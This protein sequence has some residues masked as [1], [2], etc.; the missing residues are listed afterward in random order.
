MKPTFPKWKVN[1]NEGLC[2]IS[3]NIVS[4]AEAMDLLTQMM[5]MEPSRRISA[6]AA[7]DHP[8]FKSMHH[9]SL[10]NISI[11]PVKTNKKFQLT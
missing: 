3:P 1:G 8:F 4:N 10:P 7:I 5:Q 6:K 2:N 11:S 9:T